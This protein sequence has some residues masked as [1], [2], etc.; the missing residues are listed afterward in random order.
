MP[1]VLL[2]KEGSQQVIMKRAA[3]RG[4]LIEVS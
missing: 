4:V 2:H 1:A 3:L